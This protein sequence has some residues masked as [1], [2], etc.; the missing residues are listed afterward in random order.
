[1]S[2]TNIK[3]IVAAAWP[4]KHTAWHKLNTWCFTHLPKHWSL[5]DE[6]WVRQFSVGPLQERQAPGPC[7][8]NCWIFWPFNSISPP[9]LRHKRH[10]VRRSP[11]C[12]EDLNTQ[13]LTFVH[14]DVLAGF[15]HARDKLSLKIK[16]IHLNSIYTKTFLNHSFT[17]HHTD[18]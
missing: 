15:F 7:S 12:S 14:L 6:S 8:W 2:V 1:M 10:P 5:L 9:Q 13:T 11:W 17:G 4:G 3:Q 18:T 16:V